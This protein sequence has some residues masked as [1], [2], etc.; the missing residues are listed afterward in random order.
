MARERIAQAMLAR[1]APLPRQRLLRQQPQQ[2]LSGI[3]MLD[4]LL[5]A[6]S[7]SSVTPLAAASLMTVPLGAV[8]AQDRY[9]AAP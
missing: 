3:P 1:Q 4:T 9:G 2:S 6:Q 5:P 8:A 7:V